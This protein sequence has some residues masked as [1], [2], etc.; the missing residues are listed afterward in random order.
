MKF[1]MYLEHKARPE[2][3]DHYLNYNAL[4]DLI[5]EAIKEEDGDHSAYAQRVTS[6]TVERPVGTYGSSSLLSQEIDKINKFT[7]KVVEDL[8]KRLSALSTAVD[9]QPAQKAHHEKEAKAIGD[10]FLQL[11]KYVNLNYMG[12][13][14]IL[15]KHDKNLP[16]QPYTQFFINNLH[17]QPWTMGNCS[18]ILVRLSGVHSKLRGDI[19]AQKNEDAA[20]GFVRSTTKFWVRTGDVSTVKHIV[21]QHLPVFQFDTDNFAGDAQLI[22]SAY[23]DNS[24]MELYHGRLDK[25]PNALAIRVR[26]YGPHEPNVVYFERKT[27]QESWTGEESVKERFEIDAKNVMPYMLGEYRLE[28]AIKDLHAR[29]KGKDA[30]DK[31]KK[32]FCEIQNTVESK[33]LFP[34]TRTQYMRTA[35]QIPFDSTVRMTLDTNLCMIKENPEDGPSCLEANRFYRDPKLPLTN[36]EITRFPH[37]VLEVKLS[38]QQ[39]EQAPAWVS[40]LI[41]SGLLTEVHKFSKFI[42]GGATLYP[43][44]VQS[45]P[46]WVDDE[47]VRPSMLMS[48]PRARTRAAPGVEPR[49]PLLGDAPR[50]QIINNQQ[51][52]QQ[53]AIRRHRDCCSTALCD[54]LLGVN[55][56]GSLPNVPQRIEPKSFFANERTFLSWL[57]MSITLGSIATALLGYSGTMARSSMRGNF[58]DFTV[59]ILSL[60]LLPLAVLLAIYALSVFFWRASAIRGKR[61]EQFDDPKGPI[62]L[63]S[64]IIL[65]L[66]A[67]FFINLVDLIPHLL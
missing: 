23:M 54:T 38:L 31:F 63:A 12:F 28:D 37:A 46:Y 14:K 13:H 1:G 22:N 18:D 36:S 65:A 8:R 11:E 32:I 10:E 16:H 52:R 57:N 47:S 6:L 2:W 66:T 64:C 26:W 4:K 53:V 15:K 17:N 51:E 62:V 24:S 48:A 40:E 39:G 35:F 61:V 42:H 34:T 19:A 59:D 45:V 29:G 7:T 43:E 49:H 58:T 50:I 9:S 20:Q 5:D 41:S 3:R 30:N 25:K 27:H 55:A 56:H 67:M 33:Q 21:L 60:I 44:M